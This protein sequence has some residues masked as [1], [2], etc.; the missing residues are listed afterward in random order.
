VRLVNAHKMLQHLNGGRADN[1]FDRRLGAANRSDT[2]GEL[3]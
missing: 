1:S 2:V 3:Q